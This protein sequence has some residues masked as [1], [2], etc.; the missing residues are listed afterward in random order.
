LGLRQELDAQEG[1]AERAAP[2]NGQGQRALTGKGRRGT[3]RIGGG[4]S[5]RAVGGLLEDYRGKQTI[6][7]DRPSSGF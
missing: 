6:L 7:D 2:V 5:C 1:R 4:C 3:A